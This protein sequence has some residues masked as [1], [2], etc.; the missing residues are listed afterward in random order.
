[1][2]KI[3]EQWNTKTTGGSNKLTLSDFELIQDPI[4]L[5]NKNYSALEVV[6]LIGRITNNRSSSGPIPNT[7]QVTKTVASN[8][9][10][11]YIAFTPPEG[12]VWQVGPASFQLSGAT[13]S[14]TCEQWLYGPWPESTGGD[15]TSVRV[16]VSNAS[17]SSSSYQTMNEGSPYFP[18]YIDE[19]STIKF[20]A[21]GTFTTVQFYLHAVRVR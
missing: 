11:K 2:T 10:T 18:L 21:T 3:L 1:M 14:V 6:D 9:G 4:H 15:G 12:T 16:L 20:E 13:G 8:S 17:S 5:E 7:V 19:N